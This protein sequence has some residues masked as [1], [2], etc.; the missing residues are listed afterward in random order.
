MFYHNKRNL[1]NKDSSDQIFSAM[2]EDGKVMF[3]V[4]V[5]TGGGVPL[6]SDPASCPVSGPVWGR[7]VLPGP[8][9]GPVWASSP[10]QDRGILPDRTEITPWTGQVKQSTAVLLPRDKSEDPSHAS[11]IHS[12]QKFKTGVSVIPQKWPIS[13]K[14]KKEE[15]IS[16]S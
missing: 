12:R 11:R 14:I 2:C 13:F 10:R 7:G 6:V 15:L 1:V 5:S 4:C 9:S 16:N 3:S 8:V